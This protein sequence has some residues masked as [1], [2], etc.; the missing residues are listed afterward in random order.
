MR[1]IALLAALP[2][3]LAACDGLRIVV[4]DDLDL[5][6]TFREEPRDVFHV[7]P[8]VEAAGGAGRI[9]V[10][11]RLSLPSPC[12]ELTGAAARDAERVTL[13]VTI[14]PVGEFCVGSVGSFAY[15][16]EHLRLEPGAYRL[17]VVHDVAG[18]GVPGRMVHEETVMVR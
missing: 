3:A 9:V 6:F 16:A 14:H 10:D 15:R 1:R 13:T 18:D 8:L 4:N 11:A 7:H 5:E 12:H 2:V 17:R